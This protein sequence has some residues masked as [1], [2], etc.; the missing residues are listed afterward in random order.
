MSMHAAANVT[1]ESGSYEWLVAERTVQRQ[2]G[3]HA[4]TVQT[5]ETQVLA[6]DGRYV[7]TGF[8]P[9][10]AKD[11]QAMLDWLDELGLKDEFPDSVLLQ[12]GVERGGVDYR[13]FATDAEATAIYGRAEKRCASSRP[14]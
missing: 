8:P 6:A 3:R 10:E 4:V 9:N 5:M 11:F 13:R 1:T 7:S 14:G 12:L 2:T